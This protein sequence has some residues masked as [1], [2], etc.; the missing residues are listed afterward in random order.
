MPY[1]R[2]GPRAAIRQLHSTSGPPTIPDTISSTGTPRFGAMTPT[3][4]PTSH[5]PPMI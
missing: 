4:C 5:S 3:I 1:R 2:A